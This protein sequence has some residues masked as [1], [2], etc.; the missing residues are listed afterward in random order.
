MKKTSKKSGK[1]T[2]TKATHGQRVSTS[3]KSQ[4]FREEIGVEHT[5]HHLAFETVLDGV[6][7]QQSHREPSQPTQIVPQGPLPRPAIV[8]SE[9]HIEYPVHRLDPPVST[10]RFPEPLAAQ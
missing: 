9:G 5:A 2:N 3:L 1:K 10:H 8:F 7:L 4:D 6:T